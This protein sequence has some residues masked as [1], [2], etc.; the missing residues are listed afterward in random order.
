MKITRRLS[1]AFTGGAV[2]GVIAG[3]TTWALTYVGFTALLGISLRPDYTA[4]WLFEHAFWGGL[5]MLPLIL[6]FWKNKPLLRGSTFSLLPSGVMLLWV[7]PGL[8]KGWLGM[9]YGAM[10]PVWLISLYCLYGIT[11]ALWYKSAQ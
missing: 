1:C 9:D 2:G 6:P 11:A 7:L 4:P 8:G 3:L 5:W 10:M